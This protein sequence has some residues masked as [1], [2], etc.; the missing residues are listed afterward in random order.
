MLRPLVRFIATLQLATLMVGVG[1]ACSATSLPPGAVD[2]LGVASST[3]LLFTSLG[4]GRRGNF[5]G[6][7]VK[8]SCERSAP[9]DAKAPCETSGDYY[10]LQLEGHASPYPLWVT[11][12]ALEERFRRDGLVGSRVRIGGITYSSTSAIFVMDVQPVSDRAPMPISRTSNAQSET[13]LPA[14]AR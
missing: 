10:G 2:R 6:T 5:F 3:S 4:L 8:R 13:D 14:V 9:P 1:A 11:N 7:L 12:S